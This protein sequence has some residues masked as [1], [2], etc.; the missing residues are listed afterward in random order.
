M[1]EILCLQA[2]DQATL[3]H[4]SKRPKLLLDMLINCKPD[5]TSGYQQVCALYNISTPLLMSQSYISQESKQYLLKLKG[6][7]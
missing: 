2:M 6:I 7:Y 4:Q 5:W 3:S 1:I